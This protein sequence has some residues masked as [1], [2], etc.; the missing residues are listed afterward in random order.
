MKDLFKLIF[1]VVLICYIISKRNEFE[2]LRRAIQHEASNI[3]IF[4]S[5][6]KSCL[7]DALRIAKLS[8]QRETEGIEMLTAN[9]QLN[10]LLYL[11]Q[12][13][14]DLQCMQGYNEILHKA[15]KLDED[16]AAT[17]A[18]VNGNIYEYNNAISAFP[19][20]IIALIFHYKKERFIDEEN[21]AENKKLD[22][23]ELDF[24]NY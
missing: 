14:P 13:Y 18:L 10:Q 5:K 23:S 12:K 6:K 19:G 7:D 8:Y 9:D 1:I 4:K 22:K 16:I 15:F 3:G 17:R 2:R 24:S 20:M 21:I 11:G